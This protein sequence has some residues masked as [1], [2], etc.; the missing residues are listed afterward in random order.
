MPTAL[1]LMNVRRLSPVK[2]FMFTPE[3]SSLEARRRKP[4]ESNI[5]NV[6]P[7]RGRHRLFPYKLLIE[8]DVMLFQQHQELFLIRHLLVMGFL[9]ANVF[10]H[11]PYI[12]LTNRKSTVL[13]LP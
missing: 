5:L 4:R 6:R 11:L 3:E 9:L 12:R 10:F 13:R 7:E 1:R 2:L 8:R